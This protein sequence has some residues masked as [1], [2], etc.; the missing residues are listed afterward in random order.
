MTKISWKH[1]NTEL[2]EN[3]PIGKKIEV[4]NALV[5]GS[6]LHV[7]ELAI[8][9]GRNHEGTEDVKPLPHSGFA[10][11]HILLSYFEMIARYEKGDL[12]ENDSRGT[13]IDGVLSVF[14]EVQKWPYSPTRI[15]LH[16]LYKDVRCGLYHTAMTKSGIGIWGEG[17]P[18][19]YQDN[20]PVIM[21]NPHQLAPALRQHFEGYI[22]RLNDAGETDLRQAFVKRFDRDMRAA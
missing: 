17:G 18:I 14:P 13:F 12:S 5:W 21:I 16:K 1:E 20:P 9:G 2:D 15:F 19:S 7:A 8:N 6:Q 3:S 4:F 11:L 22:A 10:V